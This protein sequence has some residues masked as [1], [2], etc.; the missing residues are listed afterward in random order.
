M[1]SPAL[2]MFH[3]VVLFLSALG[4]L[5]VGLL[6]MGYNVLGVP[7]LATFARPIEYI[8]G[9]SGLISLVTMLFM[10]SMIC[11]CMGCPRP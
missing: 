10:H 2:K 9:L 11:D 3:H 8:F 1:K 4:A 5:H 6:A 7:F